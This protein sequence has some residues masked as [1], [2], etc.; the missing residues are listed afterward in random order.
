MA[1]KPMLENQRRE[2]LRL[3]FGVAAVIALPVGFGGCSKE[4][5]RQSFV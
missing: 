2:F 1:N 4:Y 5:P 3:G